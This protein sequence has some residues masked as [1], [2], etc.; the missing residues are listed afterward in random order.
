MPWIN[1]S[2]IMLN[3]IKEAKLKGYIAYECIYIIFWKSKT[4]GTES[5]SDWCQGLEVGSGIWSK[6]WTQ[7]NCG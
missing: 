2:C 5:L 3:I 7:E 4:T 1:L 6:K